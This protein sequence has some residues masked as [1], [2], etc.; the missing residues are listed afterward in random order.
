MNHEKDPM[1][2]FEFKPLT[3]GLGFHKKSIRLRDEVSKSGLTQS[4]RKNKIPDLDE[5]LFEED[6]EIAA[7]PIE[8]DFIKT[9]ETEKAEPIA[10]RRES[11]VEIK[12]PLLPREDEKK[13][14]SVVNK[15]DTK[16]KLDFK[17]EAKTPEIDKSILQVEEKE[18]YRKIP[19]SF[20]SAL[21]DSVVGL[22]LSILFLALTM[23]IIKVNLLALVLNSETQLLVQAS[24]GLMYFAILQL[25]MIIS[26]SVAQKTLGEW[27]FDVHVAQKNG[28]TTAIFPLLVVWRA[29]LITATGVIT[30]PL[31]SM[32]IRRDI[33]S[34]LTGIQLFQQN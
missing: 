9:M 31:L 18:T 22:T 13:D 20:M 12:R 27:A 2:E 19:T 24:F 28:K 32:L 29:I 16:L 4:E 21:F 34:Y 11:S 10:S 8:K 30:L 5:L 7:S 17:E 6:A 1:E 3:E 25:Y 14:Y 23:T 15:I 26:R 33:A